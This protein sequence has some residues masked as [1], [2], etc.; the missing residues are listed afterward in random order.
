MKQ[1]KGIIIAIIIL[2]ALLI[3]GWLKDKKIQ[4][5]IAQK[6]TEEKIFETKFDD[7]LEI[8]INAGSNEF[9]FEKRKKNEKGFYDDE[10]SFWSNEFSIISS[11]LMVKPY[12][13]LAD[14]SLIETLKGNLMSLKSEKYITDEDKKA[15]YG[16]GDGLNISFKFSNGKTD[17]IELG[18]KNPASTHVYAKSSHKKGVFLVND[19]LNMFEDKKA[20]DWREKRILGFINTD[21]VQGVSYF[22][23]GSKVFQ[24]V[25]NEKGLWL[26]LQN[27]VLDKQKV[28]FLADRLNTVLFKDVS[29][30]TARPS[31]KI[32][33][34]VKEN[35]IIKEKILRIEPLKSSGEVL[36]SRPE[37]KEAFKVSNEFIE[38]FEKPAQDFYNL[39]LF[40]VMIDDVKS[41]KV[42]REKDQFE[43]IKHND[44]WIESKNKDQKN[45]K[46]FDGIYKHL[47]IEGHQYIGRKKPKNLGPSVLQIQI[48]LNDGS[49]QTVNIHALS[50]VG[51]NDQNAFIAYHEPSQVYYK[52]NN[53]DQEGLDESIEN[54][55]DNK[56]SPPKEE[57]T[58]SEEHDHEHE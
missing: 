32:I 13:A 40:D 52:F 5:E 30:S 16:V 49:K 12:R 56:K 45:A 29:K 58:I 14:H 2:F 57:S 17:Y 50:S 7:A 46:V 15:E 4:K 31:S 26:D 42:V 37:I 33:F 22:K 47:S 28:V 48:D 20:I 39:K 27:N 43:F 24:F 8:T 53:V 18:D 21:D 38:A 25:K 23:N 10:F 9:V 3:V 19:V 34:K 44:Q 1:F 54:Y 41:L 51:V 55:L 36:V 11:W 35:D 6:E